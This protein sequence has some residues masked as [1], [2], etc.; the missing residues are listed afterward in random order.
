MKRTTKTERPFYH[1]TW[2]WLFVGLVVV[3]IALRIWRLGALPSILNRDEAA[4]AYNAYLLKETGQDEWG[5]SWPL[6]LE[7]F[8][9]YKLPGYP[10]LL[11]GFFS[12]FGFSDW[13][14]RLPSAV[15]GV[16][17]ILVSFGVARRL[18]AKP[19]VATAI[20]GLVAIA[21]VF[22]FYSRIAFEANVALLLFG[23]AW[24][25]LLKPTISQKTATAFIPEKSLLISD[26]AAV[27]VML[28]AVFT[29]N[30]PFLLLPFMI[31]WLPL[32]R[33]MK[34]W[35]TWWLPVLGLVIVFLVAASMLLPIT[36]QKSSITI[37]S[38]ETVWRESVLYREQ[39]TGVW[40]RLL[41]NKYWYYV[42]L[43][44]K[45]YLASFSPSF[46]VTRGGA[47]PWH[48]VSG[49]GHLYWLVYF[50]GWIGIAHSIW[51]LLR[52]FKDRRRPVPK[53]EIILLF[54]LVIGLGP[55]VIT[56]DAPHATRSLFFIWAWVLL[57]GWGL[58]SVW[59]WA[60]KHSQ[61][62]G[63]LLLFGLSLELG[64][65]S[66]RY[67]DTFAKTHLMWKP[68]FQAALMQVDQDRP[69]SPVAIVDPDGY[70]YV[71]TAWYEHLQPATYF[72]TVI[73]QQPNQIGFRYGEQ[74]GRWHF[75]AEK[76]DRLDEEKALIFWQDDHWQV[77]LF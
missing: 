45:N 73:K 47:H 61:V 36:S 12:V 19:W 76:E 62:V 77:E 35:R 27:M 56:V 30:T 13:T 32:W 7:S 6:A 69:D 68:G 42:Q 2:W 48:Q 75:V 46:L 60:K 17:F 52:F 74:V 67:F 8:G 23:T 3:G 43:V 33:G 72:Q 21:P 51:S 20:A 16:L 10:L 59:A 64:Q 49:A 25:L 31:M 24:W 53:A 54:W 44:M 66:Y 29:Y 71:L 1:S 57:A 18:G 22:V 70:H 37:F 39:F 58:Q 34:Q 40:Q 65:F 11:I 38:D 4:L 28:G 55:A 15:A 26:L 63:L 41:G 50:L 9:D 5:V 14:V